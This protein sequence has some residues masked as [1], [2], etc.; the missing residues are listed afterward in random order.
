MALGISKPAE[1]AYAIASVN[2]LPAG[3]IGLIVVA[4]LTATMSSMD[5]NCCA[6]D[7][8]TLG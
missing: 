4:I 2:L 7:G 5:T 6:M 3:L 1:A 8:S